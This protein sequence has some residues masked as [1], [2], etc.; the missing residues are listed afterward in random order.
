MI[1][2]FKDNAKN[3]KIYLAVGNRSLKHLGKFNSNFQVFLFRSE[4]TGLFWVS[5]H[6]LI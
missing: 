6:G 5:L 3:T 1:T 4:S 2:I